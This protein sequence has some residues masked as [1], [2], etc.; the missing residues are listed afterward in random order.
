MLTGIHIL[1][2]YKCDRECEH[3]FVHAGPGA[4]GTFSLAEID[5]ILEEI[6][7]IGTIETV[8]FEGG[9][10]FLFYPI[11]RAGMEYAGARGFGVG[12]VTNAYWAVCPEDAEVWLTPLRDA[13][14]TSLVTSEDP[15]HGGEDADERPSNARAAAEKL[16]VSCSTIATERPRV[17]PPETP[18]GP[19]TVAGGVMFRGRAAETLV[20]GLPTRP[21]GEFTECP[22]EDLRDPG[23]VHVDVY[24]CVHLCQGLSM[25]NLW[26]TPLSE[27]VATYEPDAHPICGPLLEGGPARLAE[28]YELEHGDEYVSAC[29]FCYEM[30]RALLDRFPEYLGPPQVYGLDTA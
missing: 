20:E 24:G 21:C 29:H 15:L 7:R 4:R 22:H 6:T 23:R 18:G 3:C 25:G 30:R 16:G 1:L 5:Q 12:T 2:T 9:E 8:F 19:P 26:K 27:L 14:L 17:E 13:G 11:M 10:P 28:A